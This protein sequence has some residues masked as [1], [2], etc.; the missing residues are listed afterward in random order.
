MNN[1]VSFCFYKKKEKKK[2]D[3]VII[4][5]PWS[6]QGASSPTRC[7]SIT[8]PTMKDEE[9]W[10]IS[11]KDVLEEKGL[12]FIW[13]VNN[14]VDVLYSW[15]ERNDCRIVETIVWVKEEE[16]KSFTN[17]GRLFWHNKETCYVVC[18]KDVKDNDAWC[19]MKSPDVI[20]ERIREQS[21]KPDKLYITIE[22]LVPQGK[23]LEIFGRR[24]NL[25]NCLTTVTNFK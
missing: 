15:I 24:W 13:S 12:A 2:F 3:A 16:T 19:K 14:K 21:R 10:A 8:Y 4:D 20:K 5:A 7:V 25:R 17:Q 6:D 11:W 23:F 1:Y 18:R 22:K 9:L